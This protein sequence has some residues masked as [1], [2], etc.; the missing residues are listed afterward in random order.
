MT[1]AGE[2]WVEKNMSARYPFSVHREEAQLWLRA[3]CDEVEKRAAVRMHVMSDVAAIA[4]SFN[5]LKRELLG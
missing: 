5:E 4:N 2:K 1:E 3:F